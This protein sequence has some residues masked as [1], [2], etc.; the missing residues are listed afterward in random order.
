M[1]TQESCAQ[2][3][4]EE[5]IARNPPVDPRNPSRGVRICRLIPAQD[6][7]HLSRS[8]KAEQLIA[9]AGKPLVKGCPVETF[10][11]VQAIVAAPACAGDNSRRHAP[12]GPGQ[13]PAPEDVTRYLQELHE[14]QSTATD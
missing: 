14:S 5:P 7:R 10:V 13:V 9:N 8:R 1:R 12:R 6:A 2:L 4:P 11:P 3:S